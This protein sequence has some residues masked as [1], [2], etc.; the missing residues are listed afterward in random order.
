MVWG[1]YQRPQSRDIVTNSYESKS[2]LAIE[3]CYRVREQSPETWV[4]WIHASNATRFEQSCREIAERAKIP[5][6]KD[7]T[8]NVFKLLHDWLN[9]AKN[10]NWV[11]VLDNLDDDEFLHETPHSGLSERSAWSYLCQNL[12]GCVMI[13]SRSKQVALRTV[14]DYE[15]IPVEPMNESHAVSLFEKKIGTQTD[16]LAIL[17]LA[18]ALEFMP[19]AIVQAAAFIKQRAPRESITQYLERF[20]KSDKQKIRLL[21]YEGGQ[22]RRDLEAKNSI[23]VTWEISFD[24][25]RGRRPS[26]ANLLS[27]MS[28]FD[29]QGIP[30]SL[31]RE[32]QATKQTNKESDTSDTD[33]DESLFEEIDRFESD[34][35]LLKDYSM[36]SETSDHGIFQMH[37]LVQLG[38]QKWLKSQESLEHWK[39]LCIR[40][41]FQKFPQERLENWE[42]CQTLSPHV[43]CAMMHQP[44]GK[45]SLEEWASLLHK[46]ASF[47]CMMQGC[48][49]VTEMARKAWKARGTLF[50][51]E[52]EETIQ[53]S[54]TLVEAFRILGKYR[55][56]ENLQLRVI[57][58]RRRAFG[59]E[60]PTTFSSMSELA[61][62]YRE[63]GRWK[64]AEELKQQMMETSRQALGP[65]HPTTLSIMNDLASIYER[66]G[67]YKEAEELQLEVVESSNQ[68]FGP[69]HDRTLSRLSLFIRDL[70]GAGAVE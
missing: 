18:A 56:A 65:M 53:G 20:Q 5:G 1:E 54:E 46:A 6:R 50:G 37:R 58:T 9:D 28:F 3:Y 2:Q 4:F 47:I 22:I 26:A 29:R 39:E 68:V 40:K 8:A 59:P 16:R 36:I 70:R 11:L 30:D 35:L 41:L 10:S 51:Q 32:D 61:S 57:E 69:E 42:E 45:A 52:N 19:L 15:I 48:I 25:I 67:R 38:M 21:D 60:D 63:Q 12:T 33:D 64:E 17:Q 13:T 27:L 31:L 34:I 14:E 66:N 44:A 23:L 24:D 55:E 43:H 62:I 49:D 7:L